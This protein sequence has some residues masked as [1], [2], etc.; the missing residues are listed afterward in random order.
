MQ[1]LKT[2]HLL[3]VPP[4]Q[5]FLVQ[6]FGSV[7]SVLLTVG[8]MALYTS[9]YT[10][11][12]CVVRPVLARLCVQLLPQACQAFRHFRWACILLRLFCVQHTH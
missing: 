7:F 4:R 8:A 5:Q 2:G 12:G 9:A 10:V 3:R 1:D 11:R 6:V